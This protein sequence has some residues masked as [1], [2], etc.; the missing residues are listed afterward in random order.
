METSTI[1]LTDEQLEQELANRQAKKQIQQNEKRQAYED[2][3]EDTVTDGCIAALS[4]SEALLAFKSDIF[5]E[6]LALYEL[7][8]EYSSRHTDGKGNFTVENKDSTFKI[9]FSC[10]TLGYFDE[11]SVQGEKHINDFITRQFAGEPATQKLIKLALE[12]QAGKLDI[13]QV[14]KLYSMEND[15]QDANWKEGIKLLKE[16]WTQSESKDYIRFYQRVNSVWKL[17][18]LNFASVK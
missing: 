11:R 15:Y 8:Q 18:N 9:A 10:Q 5:R 6:C 12:R 17:I 13:K 2:L 14:Q 7:L 3:K 1:N 16:S 4:L